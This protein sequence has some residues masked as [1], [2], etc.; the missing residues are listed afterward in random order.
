MNTAN[1]SPSTARNDFID[2]LRGI[3]ILL[4]IEG[5]FIQWIEYYGTDL[6]YNDPIFKAIYSF[7]M[8]CFMLISGFLTYQSLQRQKAV[9]FITSRLLQL[10]IPIIFWTIPFVLIK[11][12]NDFSIYFEVKAPLSFI[13]TNLVTLSYL[14]T[15]LLNSFFDL[16]FLW[17]L[18]V[19]SLLLTFLKFIKQDNILFIFIIFT[20]IL[21]LQTPIPITMGFIKYLFPFFAIGYLLSKQIKIIT[22]LSVPLIILVTTVSISCYLLW[23]KNTYIYIS[24]MDLTINN[25]SQIGLRYLSGFSISVFFIWLCWK[26]YALKPVQILSTFGRYSLQLYILQVFLIEILS[27]QLNTQ[28]FENHQFWVSCFLAPI[29]AFLLAAILTYI[30]KLISLNIFFKSLLFGA[31]TSKK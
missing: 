3:L 5:H 31:K 30:T 6:F 13:F 23:S 19:S 12:W 26:M 2:Y 18:L 21:I 16:W 27:R 28:F 29:M 14:S 15:N 20:L 4:V 9:N 7:H 17:A 22:K 10:L 11:I 24:G 8:P 25:L 1:I